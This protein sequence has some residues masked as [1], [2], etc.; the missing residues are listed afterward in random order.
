MITKLAL[1]AIIFIM[2]SRTCKHIYICIYVYIYIY[3]Y[4]YVYLYVLL[5]VYTNIHMWDL[6]LICTFKDVASVLGFLQIA[7]PLFFD[8]FAFSLLVLHTTPNPKRG[9]KR[10]SRPNAY[11]YL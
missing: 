6:G 11:I 10:P 4:V 3:V 2:S 8:F 1:C 5:R 7:S 9:P